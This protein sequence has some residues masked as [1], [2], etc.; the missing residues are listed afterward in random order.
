MKRFHLRRDLSGYFYD[1]TQWVLFG[2]SVVKTV[3]ISPVKKTLCMLLTVGETYYLFEC[4]VTFSGEF[5]P[6]IIILWI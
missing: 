5:F 1:V 6:L 3:G 4:K 2:G